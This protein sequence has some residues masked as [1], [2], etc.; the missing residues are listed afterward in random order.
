MMQINTPLG[1]SPL[2]LLKTISL[3]EMS[4]GSVDES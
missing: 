4:N 1:I 2:D 3:S